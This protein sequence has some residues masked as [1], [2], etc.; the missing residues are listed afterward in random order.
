MADFSLN[1]T[2][3]AFLRDY[4]SRLSLDMNEGPNDILERFMKEQEQLDKIAKARV[5][6][7]EL[8]LKS[9]LEVGEITW[10]SESLHYR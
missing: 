4:S 10:T 2:T 7:R 3:S 8:S 9:K 1:E 6:M 5:K